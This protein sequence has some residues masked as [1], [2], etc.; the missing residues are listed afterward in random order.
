MD[1]KL[2]EA[3]AADVT[4]RLK[5]AKDDLVA[6]MT[7]AGL[8]PAKGWR[9]VEDLRHTVTGTQ[10]TFRPMH[11]RESSPDMETTVAIDHSGRAI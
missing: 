4:T 7:A 11:L 8:T 9:I 6:Q 3:L 10:W 5:A 2:V 1:H